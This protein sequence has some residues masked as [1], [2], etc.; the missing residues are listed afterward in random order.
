[1]KHRT[2]LLRISMAAV[3]LVLAACSGDQAGPTESVR[4][5]IVGPASHG[6]RPFL[7]QLTQEVTTTPVWSGD[8]DGRGTALIT[9]NLGKSEVCWETTVSDI[10]LPATASHIHKAGVGIR[11]PIVI[12]LSPPVATGNGN[13]FASAC[14]GGVDSELLRDILENPQD[15]Y[16]NV[17][18]SD[19][20]AGAIRGQMGQ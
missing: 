17:H 14:R 11:G 19:Y 20:P 7:Q 9:V 5:A 13:G 3:P 18:T 4:L 12:P 16:V 2:T 15:Y 8:P 1:M 6:G 10:T